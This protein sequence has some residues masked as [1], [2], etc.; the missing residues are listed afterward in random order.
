MTRV[1]SVNPQ[2]FTK[3]VNSYEN[4]VIY[5]WGEWCKPCET[6]SRVVEGLAQDY[7]P[8]V[9]FGKVDVGNG[10]GEVASAYY[11]E[12]VP[13]Y[14]LF[15]NGKVAASLSLTVSKEKIRFLLNGYERGGAELASEQA[16]DRA[17]PDS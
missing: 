6:A 16:A 5:F 9:R 15:G 13:T 11:V 3:F 4:V 12:S 10:G 7:Y 1:L 14:I 2:S 17:S 8:K